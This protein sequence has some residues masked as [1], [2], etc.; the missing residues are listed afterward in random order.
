MKDLKLNNGVKAIY[1]G[2]D[3]WSRPFYSFEFE[4]VKRTVC[5]IELNG[6][7]L[8]YYSPRNDTDG[9]PDYPL[10]QAFQPINPAP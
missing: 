2:T 6:T 7:H 8:H 9:E 5:C 1:K 3:F 4:G 10:P